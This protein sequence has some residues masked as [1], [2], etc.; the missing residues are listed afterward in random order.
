MLQTTTLKTYD[1][2]RKVTASVWWW[3]T[4][5]PLT[6]D[7]LYCIHNIPLSK[8]CKECNNGDV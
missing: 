6:W 2:L 4:N 7:N 3:A 8:K 5:T 1:G